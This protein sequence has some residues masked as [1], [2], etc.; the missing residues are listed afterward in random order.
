M[1]VLFD[2]L[3][4]VSQSHEILCMMEIDDR[5][6]NRRRMLT[7][8]TLFWVATVCALRWKLESNNGAPA[9]L[10]HNSHVDITTYASIQV[11]VYLWNKLSCM[12]VLTDI[13]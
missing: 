7:A 6:P 2:G 3:R 11:W 8:A 1:R 5:K 4:F 13:A 12:L 9:C 10:P